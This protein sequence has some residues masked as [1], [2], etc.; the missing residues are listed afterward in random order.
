MKTVSYT[1][2]QLLA[3]ANCNGEAIICVDDTLT[4]GN[5]PFLEVTVM[6]V[7][8]TWN[9]C[10]A[11]SY[12]YGFSYDENSLID[13]V[14]GLSEGS[15]HG[16]FC[17]GC[18]T[19]YINNIASTVWEAAAAKILL[20]AGLIVE[21]GGDTA[22]SGWL[23]CDGAA[24]SRGVYSDLLSAIGNTYGPGD[25]LTTFN[26][27]NFQKRFPLGKCG[28]PSINLADAGGAFNHTHSE[29]NHSHTLQNHT[30]SESA[31]T[32]YLSSH[33]HTEGFHTHDVRPHYH[34]LGSG[35]DLQ[36]F[37]GGYHSHNCPLGQFIVTNGA[38]AQTTP[39]TGPVDLFVVPFTAPATHNHFTAEF[40]GRIGLVSG[41]VDG[42]FTQATVVNRGAG[43]GGPVP[44]VSDSDAGAGTGVPVPNASG[45]S[46]GVTTG[47]ANPPYVVVNFIIKT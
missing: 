31:H 47:T 41:G 27:P 45:V 5:V 36:I 17:K 18:L 10:G 22:P 13:P 15:I 16:V 6:S 46:S 35:A 44:N 1:S 4:I 23:M 26:V 34:G 42:N 8:E 38:L 28:D 11:M 19:T 21:Y 37:A 14:S 20:P 33:I 30:H 9:T 43:T 32:H 2:A 3:C 39:Q 40:S 29:T 25:G 7:D 12:L 24:V